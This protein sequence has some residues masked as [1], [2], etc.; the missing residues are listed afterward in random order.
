[1][2]NLFERLKPEQLQILRDEENLYPL[3]TKCLK[4]GLIK[5]YYWFDLKYSEIV[6]LVSH[7]GIF[8]YS[9]SGIES[10]FNND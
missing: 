8:D 5:N 2:K 9:P 1:M 10:I 7:L 6:T 3:S 4:E